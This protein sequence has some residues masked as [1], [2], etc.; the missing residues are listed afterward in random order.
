MTVRDDLLWH[1]FNVP[2]KLDN[3]YVT[4]SKSLSLVVD[5]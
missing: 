4:P 1:L 2:Q 3:V 5:N